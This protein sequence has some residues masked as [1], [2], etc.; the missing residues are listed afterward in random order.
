V[1]E[2]GADVN[3][4][5]ANGTTPLLLA[6]QLGN[7]S[8]AQC[9]VKELGADIRQTHKR[10]GTPL[11]AASYHKHTDI[12]KWLIK[13]GANPKTSMD[14]WG[15]AA[16]LSKEAGASTEQTAY[17]E[18]KTHCSSPGCISAGIMKCTGCKTGT[19]LWGAMPAGALEGT[20]GRL[21]ALD[22][23]KE[24]QLLLKEREYGYRLRLCLLLLK[25]LR[26]PNGIWI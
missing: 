20:Q 13:A 1:K 26:Q 19:V 25:E 12:V 16:D 17:L 6:A 23:R 24:Q 2:F 3:Q 22:R 14:C 15:T 11:M 18:A 5:S 7:M 8:V 10:G 21:Q 4:G 9:L